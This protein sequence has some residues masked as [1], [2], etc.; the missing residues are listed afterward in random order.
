MQYG[1]ESP[2]PHYW[3]ILGI[4]AKNQAKSVQVADK[5]SILS[6]NPAYQVIFTLVYTHTQTILEKNPPKAAIRLK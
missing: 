2:G 6:E 4:G 1:R 5:M 3:E